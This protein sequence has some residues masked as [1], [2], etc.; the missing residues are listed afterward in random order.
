MSSASLTIEIMR[1]TIREVCAGRA[2]R[3][4]HEVHGRRALVG[5]VPIRR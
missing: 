2:E 1:R 4:A 5:D 3:V